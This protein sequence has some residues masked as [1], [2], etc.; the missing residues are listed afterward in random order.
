MGLP[1]S[2]KDL[3]AKAAAISGKAL[4]KSWYKKFLN[5]HRKR[6]IA[7]KAARLDPKRATNT[8]STAINDCLDE[9]E[10]IHAR[11]P[12]GVPPVNMD[13]KGSHTGAGREN[14]LLNLKDQN[15]KQRGSKTRVVTSRTLRSEPDE[16]EAERSEREQAAAERNK[17]K[18]EDA[19]HARRIADDALN[20]VF[21]GRL[22]TYKKDDLRA[23]A[24]AVAVSDKGTNAELLARIEDQFEQYR[25]LKYNSR[26]SGIFNKSIRVAAQRK[27]SMVPSNEGRREEEVGALGNPE[28]PPSACHL[29]L[30]V[31]HIFDPRLSL[32]VPINS[33][34][35][36]TSIDTRRAT[37][38]ALT[39]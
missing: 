21:T 34:P 23:L 29:R 30:T 3:E 11:F 24:I 22:G 32:P 19:E 17:K 35:N 20:R 10:T 25:D 36:T 38:I 5:R 33:H 12:G 15:Q 39:L 31:P 6:L 26:F 27:G 1:F 37:L 28:H 7:A 2:R 16:E 13:E 18:A 4:G 9:L 8:S 14:K